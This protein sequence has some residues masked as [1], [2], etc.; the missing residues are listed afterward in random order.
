MVTFVR[1]TTGRFSQRPHYKPEEL[2]R[3][4]ETIIT[5]FLKGLY[6]KATFPVKTDDLTKLIER[7][8]SDFDSY[9]DLSDL[10][11][12]V[13]GVTEFYPGRKP[14]VKIAAA[15]ANDTRREN[16]LRTTMTHEFGH[17]RLH[18]YLW[19]MEPPTADLLKTKPNANKQICKRETI[20][21]ARETDWMEWQAGYVCGAL[22]MPASH[23]RRQLRAYV[24]THNIYG[25]VSPNSAHASALI[26]TVVENF[27][28]SEDA[29]RIRL[30]KLGV[31]GTVAPTKSLFN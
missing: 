13:D 3:E 16:R 6:G 18:A 9:A 20:L 24:E 27:Q 19:E 5:G 4:C 31:L 15:L 28:V 23:V 29:A 22:L 25:A 7:D 21:N 30:L 1:D 8:T 12:D 11:A 26:S 17:V 14:V 2:D 10:G